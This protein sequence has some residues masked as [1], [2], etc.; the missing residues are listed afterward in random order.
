MPVHFQGLRRWPVLTTCVFAVIALGAVLL[1]IQW[2]GPTGQAP[3]PIP[4]AA[5]VLLSGGLAL[6]ASRLR[7]RRAARLLVAAY[8]ALLT[9]LALASITHRLGI[10]PGMSGLLVQGPLH[11]FSFLLFFGLGLAFHDSPRP[12][13]AWPGQVCLFVS[14][15]IA[16]LALMG[17]GLNHFYP[18]YGESAIN[19]MPLA[20]V[21]GC[22]LLC[23]GAFALHPARGLAHIVRMSGPAGISAR[24]LL[25]MPVVVPFVFGSLNMWAQRNHWYSP[26]IG[27]WIFSLTNTIFFGALVWWTCHL[28]YKTDRARAR[29]RAALTRANLDLEARVEERTRALQTQTDQLARSNA[30]LEQFAYV[31]SHDL[32]EPLRI[33][34][35]YAQL[36]GSRYQQELG[37]EGDEFL[38]TIASNAQ[39]MSNLVTDLLAY[40]RAVHEQTDRQ[41][42]DLNHIL[43]QAADICALTITE[44]GAT[45]RADHPLPSVAGDPSQLLQVFQNLLT[46]SLKYRSTD[47]PVISVCAERQGADC[48][49]AWKDNGIGIDP[50][51]HQKVFVLFQ[52]L[53][54]DDYPGTG[55]GL[56]LCRRIVQEHG[57]DIWV[58]SA[59]GSGATFYLRLPAAQ[60]AAGA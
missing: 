36:L 20:L 32:Q 40:S 22:L 58:D 59:A 51:Y 44:T 27:G 11:Y 7:N 33:V 9:L 54:R 35:I 39:R 3:A 49:L 23:L 2:F 50:Q 31:A 26:V 15:G 37:P 6:A 47:P 13:S 17:H 56:A 30:E 53:H 43:A 41:A 4:S 34:R 1:V 10:G 16:C 8:G 42:V 60:A 48:L 57:G 12:R 52:R 19:S 21:S 45:L 29:A 55:V 14:S 25:P 24:R 46:N 5:A 38:H 18:F 28:L